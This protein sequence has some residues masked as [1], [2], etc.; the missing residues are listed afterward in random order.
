VK[1]AAGFRGR[2]V[3]VSIASH[4]C[5]THRQ[6]DR[7]TVATTKEFFL[8]AWRERLDRPEYRTVTDLAGELR[9]RGIDVKK[10]SAD[11]S[12]R[13]PS[14]L[15][16][17]RQWAARRAIVEYQYR[18][19]IDFQGT[20]GMLIRTDT[21]QGQADSMPLVAQIMRTQ[22][23][24]GLQEL[25]EP[26]RHRSADSRSQLEPATRE[27]EREGALGVRVTR[28]RQDILRGRATVESRFL[29]RM[30]DGTWETV[31]LHAETRDTSK[32]QQERIH[33]IQQD[34][35]VRQVQQVIQTLGLNVDT[36][37]FQTALRF[38]AA[39]MEAQE[40]ANGRFYE[41]RDTY[42]ER[43]DRPPLP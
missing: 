11:L 35:Q 37:A 38:G 14:R 4:R 23:A 5:A 39:T 34:P 10:A 15:D 3:G 19:T 2:E 32:V 12:D 42:L 41:F 22:L 29:G 24:G 9:D 27:A 43:L 20:G 7:T 31:W 17:E 1:I 33:R 26:R 30:P 28:I 36:N 40:A 25:L 18:R 13:L 8:L 21:M 16:D 6:I